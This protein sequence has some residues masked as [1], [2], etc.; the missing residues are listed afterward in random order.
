[1]LS[2]KSKVENWLVHSVPGTPSP[3]PLKPLADANSRTT[4]RA[5]VNEDK[6]PIINTQSSWLSDP[7]ERTRN[8][9]T[10][11]NNNNNK[12]AMYNGSR[13]S[14]MNNKQV[15][16]MVNELIKRKPVQI[17]ENE[18]IFDKA[19][20]G[21]QKKSVNEGGGGGGTQQQP[22]WVTPSTKPSGVGPR[23][24]I[25]TTSRNNVT[26]GELPLTLKI[27]QTATADM[28]QSLYMV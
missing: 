19:G 4:K 10:N 21:K 9:L 16:N 12:H 5:K 27:G 17:R 3:V 6:L 24:P 28:G 2:P 20:N 23:H 14:D 26:Y 22:E 1:M 18:N 8:N 25:A 11:N 13:I 15:Y 7:D